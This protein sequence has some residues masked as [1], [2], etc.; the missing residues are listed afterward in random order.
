MI[1]GKTIYM[2]QLHFDDE[3]KAKTIFLFDYH[4]IKKSKWRQNIIL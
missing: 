1:K 3:R 2:C 4:Q